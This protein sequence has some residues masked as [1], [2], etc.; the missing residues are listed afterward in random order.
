MLTVQQVSQDVTSMVDEILAG[1]RAKQ[2]ADDKKDDKD[3][4]E[5]PAFL[6]GGDKDKKDKDD[7]KDKKDGD[8]DK[9]DDKKDDKEKKASFY[10]QLS[11]LTTP[12]QIIAAA[13]SPDFPADMAQMAKIAA[14]LKAVSRIREGE[15][16]GMVVNEYIKQAGV[17]QVLPGYQQEVPLLTP[18]ALQKLASYQQQSQVG[19]MQK[20]AAY[21]DGVAEQY[22]NSGYFDELDK[23]AAQDPLFAALREAVDEEEKTASLIEQEKSAADQIYVQSFEEIYDPLMKEA[24]QALESG[25]YNQIPFISEILAGLQAA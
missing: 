12:E 14:E 24:A 3:K 11:G 19:E 5:L 25:N 2:A 16:T 1:R 13:S 22:F 15:I 18:D 10:A 7:D 23:L 20:F 4:K 6:Q 8:K 9:D 21:E 17:G